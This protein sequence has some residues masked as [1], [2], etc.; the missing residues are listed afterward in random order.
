[1]E[2][3]ESPRDSGRSACLHPSPI[4]ANL[5]D[6]KHP[7]SHAG[8]PTC[9]HSQLNSSV[10]QRSQQHA[11]VQGA[12]GGRGQGT[13]LCK[14]LQAVGGDDLNSTLRRR[15]EWAVPESTEEISEAPSSFVCVLAQ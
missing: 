13:M 7:C 8:P 3:R 15:Q 10:N 1:M 6:A 2:T 12:G 4:A 11:D 5:L 14:A 9:H